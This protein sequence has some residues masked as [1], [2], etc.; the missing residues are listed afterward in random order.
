L[1]ILGARFVGK[2]LP[3]RMD[4]AAIGMGVVACFS[5]HIQRYGTPAFHFQMRYFL[6]GIALLASQGLSQGF[7]SSLSDWRSRWVLSWGFS[8][9]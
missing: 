3:V 6:P 4:V 5:A 8:R 7:R 2:Y 9:E 1:V